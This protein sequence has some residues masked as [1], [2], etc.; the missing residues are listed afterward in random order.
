[1]NKKKKGYR[2]N[3]LNEEMTTMYVRVKDLEYLENLKKKQSVSGSWVVLKKI[4]ETV[5]EMK[6]ESEL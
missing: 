3:N 2:K 4:I 6:W 1:M 5:K